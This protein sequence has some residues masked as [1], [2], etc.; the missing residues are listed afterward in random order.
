MR[1]HCQLSINNLSNSDVSCFFFI[2]HAE[3]FPPFI[4]PGPSNKLKPVGI[5]QWVRVT[6]PFKYGDCSSGSRIML[7]RVLMWR[8]F[9]ATEWICVSS[10]YRSLHGGRSYYLTLHLSA[11]L[12]KHINIFL[13]FFFINFYYSSSIFFKETFSN[14]HSEYY[15]LYFL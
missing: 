2:M 8:S 14:L 6:K 4:D 15:N 7:S 13:L 11:L 1:S 3:S 9:W 12:L 10:P 5:S